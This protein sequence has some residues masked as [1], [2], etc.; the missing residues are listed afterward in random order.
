MFINYITDRKIALPVNANFVALD[1]F[2][3]N[4]INDDLVGLT[5]R[6]GIIVKVEVINRSEIEPVIKTSTYSLYCKLDITEI[7]VSSGDHLYTRIIQ[8]PTKTGTGSSTNKNYKMIIV[9][10]DNIYEL[11]SKHIKL[12]ISEED[13]TKGWK[14]LIERS[15][16]ANSGD[17]D[18]DVFKQNIIKDMKIGDYITQTVVVVTPASLGDY[19]F[20]PMKTPGVIPTIK[21]HVED[22]SLFPVISSELAKNKKLHKLFSFHDKAQLE[23]TKPGNYELHLNGY[24]SIEKDS[25]S[26]IDF[27]PDTTISDWVRNTYTNWV[28]VAVSYLHF[29]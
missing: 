23:I 19:L 18:D 8:E 2:I 13:Y 5:G 17:L 22:P 21:F 10:P 1:D 9:S 27:I 12:D 26:S 15:M 28:E 25:A 20:L 7:I 29:M 11:V 3:H 6:K 4:Y 24:V 16:L 14:L